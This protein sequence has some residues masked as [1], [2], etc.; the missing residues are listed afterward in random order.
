MDKNS[1]RENARTRTLVALIKKIAHYAAHHQKRYFVGSGFA[2]DLY[3]GQ[4]TRE[5]ED[6][7][8]VV[9]LVDGKLWR[10]LFNQWGYTIGQDDYMVYFPNAFTVSQNPQDA[11]DC[12]VEVWAMHYRDDG[13]LYPPHKQE[14]PGREWWQAKR[15]DNL[16]Y[17]QFE[18][19]G[20]WI[21]EPNVT[22]NQKLDHVQY[23]KQRLSEKHIHDL[24]LMGRLDEY[25][26][27]I[28]DDPEI[29]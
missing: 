26:R 11:E 27:I 4:L 2:I 13:S 3:L 18:G 10:T 7:D 9:D 17:M 23:H 20:V 25:W 16:Q 19:V 28:Q 24:N 12:L 21:E 14:H 1:F 5:H 22:I 8:L 29:K 15:H 6:I